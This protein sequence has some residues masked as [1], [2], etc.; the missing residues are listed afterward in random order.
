MY[1]EYGQE[2]SV[3]LLHRIII[4]TYSSEPCAP[5]LQVIL[6]GLLSSKGFYLAGQEK[7]GVRFAAWYYC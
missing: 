5:K 1:E 3:A 7:D 6:G 4:T 2:E